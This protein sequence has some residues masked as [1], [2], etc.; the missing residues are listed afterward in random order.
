MQPALQFSAFAP[1][2]AFAL[3]EIILAVGAMVLL[4][5]GAFAGEKSV[6]VVTVLATAV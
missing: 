6:R 1:E 4:M 3:P 5:V 2:L